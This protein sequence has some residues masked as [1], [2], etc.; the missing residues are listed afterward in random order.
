MK[1]KLVIRERMDGLGLSVSRA[2]LLMSVYVRTGIV[3][4]LASAAI[5]TSGA[6]LAAWLARVR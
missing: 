4:P 2:G 3:L 5:L 1:T 6:V